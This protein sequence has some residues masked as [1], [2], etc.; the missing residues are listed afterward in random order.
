MLSFWSHF[1]YSRGVT[2]SSEK[3]IENVQKVHSHYIRSFFLQIFIIIRRWPALSVHLTSTFEHF[4][5]PQWDSGCIF[6]FLSSQSARVQAI[7][8]FSPREWRFHM[9]ESFIFL[10]SSFLLFLMS[11]LFVIPLAFCSPKFKCIFDICIFQM[12]SLP[13]MIHIYVI[14]VKICFHYNYQF[15][16]HVS[17]FGFCYCSTPYLFDRCILTITFLLLKFMLHMY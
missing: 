3:C 15:I 4:V 2:A 14:F 17:E 12:W 8:C 9:V 1:C 10:L 11:P 7:F 6:I 13:Q 16:Y 5:S